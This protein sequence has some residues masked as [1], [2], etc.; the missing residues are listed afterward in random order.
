MPLLPVPDGT[1]L[2]YNGWTAPVE[3]WTEGFEIA[4]EAGS[5]GRINVSNRYTL[6]IK[7]LI[8]P[9]TPGASLDSKIAGIK[10]ALATSGGQLRYK[11][12]GPG[13]IELN[14]PGG[15]KELAFGPTPKLISLK[16]EAG[17]LAWWLSFT[18]EFQTLD[19]SSF[20]SQ[21]DLLE[22]AYSVEFTI[23][24]RRMT[25]RN[26]KGHIRI[27]NNRVAPDSRSLN[28]SVDGYFPNIVPE[29]PV[30]F[31]RQNEV[32]TVSE[33]K[34][35]LDFSFTDVQLMVAPPFGVT[36]WGAS[37]KT[38]NLKPNAFSGLW[39]GALRA[40]YEVA[41]HLKMSVAHGHFR[42]LVNDRVN[43]MLA[44]TMIDQQTGQPNFIPQFFE[45]EEDLAERVMTYSFTYNI[46]FKLPRIVSA[47]FW[48]PAPSHNYGTFAASMELAYRPGGY[49]EMSISRTE[50]LLVNLCRN[51]APRLP[52]NDSRS[53]PL[54]PELG[55]DDGITVAVPD[56]EN[57]WIYYELV[58]TIS[59]DDGVVIAKPLPTRPMPDPNKPRPSLVDA[60]ENPNGF[61]P[62]PSGQDG[63][64]ASNS[65]VRLQKRTSTTIYVWLIGRARRAAYPISEPILISFGDAL[66][67]PCNRPGLEYFSF[68]V[69]GNCGVPIYVAKFKRRYVLTLSPR[70]TGQVA[71]TGG[72]PGS[73]AGYPGGS[74]GVSTDGDWSFGEGAGGNNPLP[75][76]P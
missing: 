68:A 61:S 76:F 26:Y 18:I 38:G 11:G 34:S 50:D 49:A 64:E 43:A 32:R 12:R 3:C 46:S 58:V 14:Y 73:G 44:E 41:P 29:C 13:N 15:S 63:A 74:T 24:R 52:D 51:D 33:D 56:P 47:G 19:C 57:S 35:R 9:D 25:H 55:E 66:A 62:V 30:E 5:A 31:E 67:A 27:P 22:F 72:A 28:D 6:K 71:T 8:T 37:H 10:T 4:I 7:S 2:S 69:D 70:D 21:F 39:T 75:P 40:R 20:V 1:E 48:R 60:F 45:M 59:T 53:L 54:L 16:P 42:A 17:N 23:D 36:K 65:S